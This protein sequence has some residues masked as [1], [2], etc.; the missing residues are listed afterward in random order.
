MILYLE[1]ASH[2]GQGTRELGERAVT[3]SLD[4]PALVAGEAGRNQFELGVRG[5]LSTLQ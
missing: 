5:F 4:E 2:G 3:R 1:R